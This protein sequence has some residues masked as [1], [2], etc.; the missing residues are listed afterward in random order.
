MRHVRLQV[1]AAFICVALPSLN[2]NE[3]RAEDEPG[4]WAGDVS[5]EFS[6]HEAGADEPTPLPA[7]PLVSA[8]PP[9]AM[10]ARVARRTPAYIP[11]DT[12]ITNQGRQVLGFYGGQSAVATLSQMP[13]RTS[14]QT[15]AAPPLVPRGKQFQ[16][17]NNN[18]PTVSP[19]LNLF[20]DENENTAG[21][22]NYYAFVKPQLDQR[23]ASERQ[24]REMQQLQRQMQRVAGGGRYQSNGRACAGAPARFMDTAQFYGNWQR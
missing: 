18:G 10:P 2:L 17:V 14:I 22:P 6:S 5:R 4:Y 19:Y 21:L 13:R 16:A 23:D 9:A 8:A 1:I 24:Q 11:A 20:R 7:Q 12:A 3:L 15:A